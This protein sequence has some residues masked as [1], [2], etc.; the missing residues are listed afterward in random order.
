MMVLLKIT[1]R[2]KE[3][4]DL[5]MKSQIEIVENQINKDLN[6]ED[7]ES[8]ER[9]IVLIQNSWRMMSLQLT[10]NQECAFEINF[11]F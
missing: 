8:L 3:A 5:L 10:K 7:I 2:N 1:E 11:Q 9:R 6:F 4:L